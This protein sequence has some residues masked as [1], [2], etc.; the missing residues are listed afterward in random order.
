MKGKKRGCDHRDRDGVR[1]GVAKLDMIHHG[2]PQ[3]LNVHGSSAQM[4]AYQNMKHNWQVRLGELMEQ[5]ALPP[6][7]GYV[8]AEGQCCF[9]DRRARDQ[10]NFRFMLEKA[11][12]DALVE[13]GYLEDDD[14]SRYEFGR[15]HRAYQKGDSWTA[16]T[17]F[18]SWQRRNI[19]EEDKPPDDV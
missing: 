9:P 16:L 2:T 4:F 11:L 5:A 1:C 6:K 8:Y 7:L 19:Y 15:L 14:W 3:S 10:G 18:P 17:L 13:Y 12:G